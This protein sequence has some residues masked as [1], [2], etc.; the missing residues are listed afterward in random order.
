M[1][2]EAILYAKA[3][4]SANNNKYELAIECYKQLEQITSN[5]Y[6][7]INYLT[8]LGAIYELL[9]KN[10]EAITECYV[11]IIKLHPNN[12]VIL[13][14][15]GICYFNQ[16]QFKL[17]IHN[18]KKI[19]KIKEL[20]DVYN[21]IG[22]CY[23]NMADYKNAEKNFLASYNLDKTNDLTNSLLGSLFY[24][25]KQYDTSIMHY[26]KIKNINVIDK[27]LYNLCFPYLAKKQFEKGFELYETRLNINSTT[28]NQNLHD[29]VQIP[30]L[31]NW[32]GTD[33]CDRLLVAGEQGLGDMIQYY[34][35]ILELADSHP[36]IKITF[37]CKLELAHLFESFG[38]FDVVTEF[39][40]VTL[41][42]FEYKAYL[43][44]LPRLLR[45]KNIIPNSIE[46]IKTD[47]DKILK[48]KTRLNQI[49][50]RPKVGFVYS[51]LLSSFIEKHIPLEEF[52]ILCDL[53]V[54]LICIHR[55]SDISK[56][57]ENYESHAQPNNRIHFIDIDNKD[58]GN[59]PFEDTVNIL[60]SLDLLITIDTITV[61]LAG[62]LNIKTWLLLGHSEWRWSDDPTSTYWYN[63]V[64]LIRTT[65]ENFKD[66]LKTKVKDKLSLFL[67]QLTNS[68]SHVI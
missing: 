32:N 62:V 68:H 8:E 63:S 45:V 42:V 44:S 65:G 17:A 52:K 21:N 37:F 18:F 15:I 43:M 48:W 60:K 34:R 58:N 12:G 30:F 6:F 7:L 64:E 36:E 19:L 27:N 13:N 57:I 61:H 9:N 28:G 1:N 40:Y 3:K 46:Y 35:F 29:R 22:N 59:E 26:E 66:I 5:P 56:D 16:G 39:N 51:G 41:S 47:N 53:D 50:D 2:T 54:D 24:Y 11:K 33:K 49:S 14:Q 38:K 20:P 25:T 55:K 23:V 31:Q 67:T 4:D 10:L